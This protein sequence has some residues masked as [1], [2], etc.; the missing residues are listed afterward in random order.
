M[1]KLKDIKN[2]KI[3]E[4]KLAEILFYTFPLSFIIGNFLLSLH[5]LLFIVTSLFLIKKEQLTIR[6]NN[7]YWILIFFF[8]YF[9]LSTTIQYP[10]RNDA[11][12]KNKP[13]K[14]HTALIHQGNRSNCGNSTASWA[15]SI[16]ARAFLGA[17]AIMSG[18]TQ[19]MQALVAFAVD[20][21]LPG[22]AQYRWPASAN[23]MA[24]AVLRTVLPSK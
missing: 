13:Q 10:N 12:S 23:Q 8:L 6:F 21:F 4:I 2:Q 22:P 11:E 17:R 7:S 9:F 1:I 3:N 20:D 18:L 24:Y 5:L 15:I 16:Q 14:K 19:I